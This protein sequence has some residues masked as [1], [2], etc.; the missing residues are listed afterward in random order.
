MLAAGLAAIL[1]G[2]SVFAQG[3]A[4]G[5]M[6]K[7]AAAG[8]WQVAGNGGFS[9]GDALGVSLAF[10]PSGQP[11]VAFCDR[12]ALN[13][14]LM[15]L[16]GTD[17]SEVG[18]I[19]P[20]VTGYFPSLAFDPAGTPMVGFRQVTGSTG[21]ASLLHFNGTSWE[22]TG[23]SLFSAGEVFHTSLAVNTA[24]TPFIV[25]QDVASNSKGTVMKFDGNAWVN[26]GLPGFTPGFARNPV[27]AIDPAGNPWVAFGSD[28]SGSMG[29]ATVMKLNGSV[30]ELV[31]IA[32]FSAG[33]MDSISLAFSPAGDPWVAYADGANGWRATV[34]RFDGSGWVN[35][36]SPGFSA[37]AAGWTSLG[38]SQGGQAIV[39]FQD[40]ANGYMASAMIFDGTTWIY[41]G[42]PGFTPGA[43]AQ[44]TLRISQ[45]GQPWV[46]FTDES[47]SGRVTVMMYDGPMGT[48]EIRNP[49]IYV[50]PNPVGS[51]LSVTVENSGGRPDHFD[52]LDIIGN[53]VMS[54]DFSGKEIRQHVE[55]LAPGIYFI[56]ISGLQS[57]F[58]ARFIKR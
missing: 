17:W 52:I 29:R 43:C 44:T 32:G 40:A 22:F 51:L 38:F 24:G 10:H 50:Y 20:S 45:S 28:Q 7:A 5:Q 30:W 16:S 18:Q 19:N 15:A 46:A 35:A 6:S 13:L 25:Y 4:T 12:A 27:I 42:T 33:V 49:G 57:L 14:H 36:G 8:N 1:S 11:C 58:T 2:F 54:A 3:T 47:N 41:L 56:K 26:A 37:G 34:M 9:A 53:T 48:G 55:N 39:A 31:G 21:K 23:N